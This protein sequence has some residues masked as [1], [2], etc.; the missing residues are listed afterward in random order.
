MHSLT[1]AARQ[2]QAGARPIA[3]VAVMRATMRSRNLRGRLPGLPCARARFTFP[4]RLR[5]LREERGPVAFT[6]D[7]VFR[8]TTVDGERDPRADGSDHR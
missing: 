1:G 2:S 5:A 6:R 3:F 8:C 4:A 7:H